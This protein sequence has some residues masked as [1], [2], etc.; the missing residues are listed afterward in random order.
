MFYKNNF[1]GYCFLTFLLTLLVIYYVDSYDFFINSF[2]TLKILSLV[3]RDNDT[4]IECNPYIS[5]SKFFTIKINN[6]TYPKSV[7]LSRN[8]SI[9]YECLNQ[10]KKLKVILLWNTFFGDK[11]FAFGLG[12]RDLFIQQK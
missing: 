3:Y 1:L 7:P 2:K 6:E 5:N 4:N 12:K 11:K 8:N 10:N 9:N